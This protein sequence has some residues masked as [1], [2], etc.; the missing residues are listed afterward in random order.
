MKSVLFWIAMGLAA[1]APARRDGPAPISSGRSSAVDGGSTA[2]SGHADAM[3]PSGRNLFV[4]DF[5]QARYQKWPLTVGESPPVSGSARE[6]AREP[7]VCRVLDTLATDWSAPSKWL[8][9]PSPSRPFAP[10]R[11]LWGPNGDFF[12]LDRTGKRLVLYDTN[13]Q[14]LSGFPLPREIR[15]RNLD[16]FE[17]FWTRDGVFTFLDMG[18]G[19]AWQYSESR[20]PG[21]QP[22][23]RL[24]S[25]ADLPV[26]L[27]TCLWE[28]YFREPCCLRKSPDRGDSTAE[29]REAVS[30]KVCFDRFFGGVARPPAES[31]LPGIRPVPAGAAP[32]WML[33]L[34]G[35]PGCGSPSP[36]CFSPEVGIRSTCPPVPDTAPTR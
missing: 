8:A 9:L 13:A 10:M 19:K 7:G 27:A 22:D 33:I 24:R 35:G 21:G 5:G 16:R 26:G 11:A 31:A 30:E 15:E 12:L 32:E 6:I 25:S 23:W 34:D 28:P 4:F 29:G 3:L 1:C 18:E 17:A 14:F 2:G 20:T 36:A